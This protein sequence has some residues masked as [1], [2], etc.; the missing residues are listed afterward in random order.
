VSLITSIQDY[1]GARGH[2][3]PQNTSPVNSF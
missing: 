1:P 2:N 3:L